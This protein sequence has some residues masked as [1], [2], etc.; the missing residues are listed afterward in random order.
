MLVARAVR[1]DCG[2]GLDGLER[3]QRVSR[4]LAVD[5]P[6]FTVLQSL[7]LRERV[8]DESDGDLLYVRKR[9]PG[10]LLVGRQRH[11]LVLDQAG[12]RVRAIRKEDRLVGRH[13]RLVVSG[14]PGL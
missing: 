8:L 6:D 7:N 13:G 5:D 12:D 3:A 4:R 14:A 2:R 1:A 9:S 10:V 11:E